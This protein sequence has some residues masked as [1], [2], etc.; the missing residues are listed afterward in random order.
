MSSQDVKLDGGK[1]MPMNPGLDALS[2]SGA[3]V[4]APLFQPGGDVGEDF[5]P[6][7]GGA[8]EQ[9]MP[10]ALDTEP[11]AAPAAAGDQG[12]VP[13]EEPADAQ[14]ADAAEEEVAVGSGEAAA[15]GGAVSTGE[16]AAD[17]QAQMPE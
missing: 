16:D 3:E 1:A 6:A 14:A 12:A 10:E 4:I 11:I 2:N 9:L 7:V 17:G 5:K 13:V 8:G 15:G